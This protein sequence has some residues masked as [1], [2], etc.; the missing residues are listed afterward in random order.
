MET[1]TDTSPK[2]HDHLWGPNSNEDRNICLRC[3][4]TKWGKHHFTSCPAAPLG[5]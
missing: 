3:E 4:A 2:G 5:G 1:G